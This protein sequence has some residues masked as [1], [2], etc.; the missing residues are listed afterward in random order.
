[1]PSLQ[2]PRTGR[3]LYDWIFRVQVVAT[4]ASAIR[5]RRADEDNSSGLI[6]GEKRWQVFDGC[7][8][9]TIEFPE[10][11]LCYYDRALMD[12]RALRSS[13]G[14]DF[15]HTNGSQTRLAFNKDGT[16]R[17]QEQYLEELSHA[18]HD[19]PL[20]ENLLVAELNVMQNRSYKPSFS[21][22]KN[23]LKG[24]VFDFWNIIAI[25][26][27]SMPHMLEMWLTVAAHIAKAVQSSSWTLGGLSDSAFIATLAAIDINAAWVPVV[28]WTMAVVVGIIHV[29]ETYH[30]YVMKFAHVEE[31][32]KALAFKSRC[33]AARIAL[34]P[35][36]AEAK[37][38]NG[39]LFKEPFQM[40]CGTE[41]QSALAAQ[42]ASTN[43]ALRDMLE[44]IGS[45]GRCLYPGKGHRKSWHNLECAEV[46]SEAM[47]ALRKQP[48]FIRSAF[49]FAAV[50]ARYADQILETPLYGN[51]LHDMLEIKLLPRDETPGDLLADITCTEGAKRPATCVSLVASHRAFERTF[52]RYRAAIRA[53]IKTYGRETWHP[54][55]I[56]SPKPCRSVIV[57]PEES[58]KLC[59]YEN[60]VDNN[61]KK[62]DEGKTI[63]EICQEAKRLYMWK[64]TKANASKPT[65]TT[66][67]PAST[68]QARQVCDPTESPVPVTQGHVETGSPTVAPTVGSPSPG[69]SGAAQ[70]HSRVAYGLA[71]VILGRHIS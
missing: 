61:G 38:L 11:N 58:W 32:T 13:S 34:E 39:S 8:H 18:L 65:T 64:R 42:Y 63:D 15:W 60:F 55:G 66:V 50:Y 70:I 53:Y 68:T 41:T 51:T 49:L 24:R 1:M 12:P 48:G 9:G 26:I 16:F 19:Q 31:Y 33:L 23:R 67:P 25:K 17:A 4:V 29:Y 43:A 52:L 14:V 20:M 71:I 54:T 22:M 40:A 62:L 57:K 3:R 47:Y 7:P 69:G 59:K 30:H 28:G 36:D 56:T 6:V 46:L 37:Y 44:E 5:S 10:Y 35:S 21:E 45:V 2:P 27:P